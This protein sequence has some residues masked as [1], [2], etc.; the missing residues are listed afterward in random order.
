MLFFSVHI[1]AILLVLLFGVYENCFKFYLTYLIFLLTASVF[2]YFKQNSN[3]KFYFNSY[4]I[5]SLTLIFMFR[6]DHGT[7]WY[8]VDDKMFYEVAAFDNV[9]DVNL[10]KIRWWGYFFL[11]K[12][13]YLLVR[14]FIDSGVHFYHGI[15]LNTFI[16]SF[17]PYLYKKHFRDIFPTKTVD[18]LLIFLIFMPQF[19]VY[20]STYLRDSIIMLLFA[21]LIY[22]LNSKRHLEIRKIGYSLIILIFAYFIRPGSSF[23]LLTYIFIHFYSSKIK[24]YLLLLLVILFIVDYY[25]DFQFRDLESISN[26][27]TELTSKEASVN[28]LGAKLLDS[29]NLLLF[30]IKFLYV[31]FSPIPPPILFKLSLQSIV[32][33]VGLLIKY[34]FILIYLIDGIKN[35]FSNNS[36]FRKNFIYICIITGAILFSSRDPRHLNYLLPLIFVKSIYLFDYKVNLI[37]QSILYLI[38]LGPLIIGVYFILKMD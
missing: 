14:E 33:S 9:F 12:Q 30:P 28:S 16:S 11:L 3:L 2:D 23:F 1:T 7:P 10:L 35:F 38:L 21:S 32:F 29:N 17:I 25:Y 13:F 34:F 15:L 18:K 5:G 24:L 6:L 26:T 4:V 27:Y 36:D 31:L 22:F 37:K 8:S 20:N 19:V